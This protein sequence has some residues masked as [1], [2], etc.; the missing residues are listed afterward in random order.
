MKLVRRGER[1]QGL[2]FAEGLDRR[3][4]GCAASRID[5]RCALRALESRFGPFIAV[6]RACCWKWR[7]GRAWADMV[8]PK[9]LTAV[10]AA[11]T[12]DDLTQRL[13]RD[14]I[15]VKLIQR[16][17]RVQGLAFAAGRDPEAPG[18]GASR[19]HPR[20]KKAALEQRF[21]PFPA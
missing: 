10:D 21:G 3:A 8:R 4:P 2:A 6:A 18:C 9:I 16:G 1:V 15:V 19:I 5:S 7:T 20:C 14:G 13:D 17:T 12:W 11:K